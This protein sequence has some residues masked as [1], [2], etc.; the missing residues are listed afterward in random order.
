VSFD[1]FLQGW[2]GGVAADGD[3]D[4]GMRVLDPLVVSRE[5]E[6]GFARIAT[7][8]GGADVY[9]IGAPSQ[10]FMFNHASGRA[11]WDVMYEVALAAGFVVMAVG[12]PVCVTDA[13]MVSELPELPFATVVVHSGK[14]IL[15]A[16]ETV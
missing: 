12:C 3:G 10:G 15:R 1:I 4:A 13:A 7:T 5:D 14:D 9:G 2:R 11:V 16:V 6:Y 8:D